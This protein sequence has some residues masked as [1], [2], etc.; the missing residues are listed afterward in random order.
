[1]VDLDTADERANDRAA[2]E[3]ISGLEALLHLSGEVF[4]PTN[5]QSQFVLE[6]LRVRELTHLLVQRVDALAL[7]SNT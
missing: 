1:M 6:R 2:G 7:S 4:Q 3:P 5:H